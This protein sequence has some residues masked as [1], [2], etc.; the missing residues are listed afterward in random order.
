MYKTIG[1]KVN[2]G[3]GLWSEERILKHDTDPSEVKHISVSEYLKEN[4]KLKKLADFVSKQIE[5]QSPHT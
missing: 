1:K 4:R 5:L 3:R 2:H